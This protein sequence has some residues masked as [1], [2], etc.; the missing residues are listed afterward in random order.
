MIEKNFRAYKDVTTRI[1]I[2]N[3]ELAKLKSDWYSISGI[4][5]DDVKIKG[6]KPV[7]IADQLHNIVEKEKELIKLINQKEEIRRVHEKEISKLTDDKKRMILTF[8][9]LDQYSIKEIAC[10]LKSSESHIKKLK[11]KAIDEFIE[12][13]MK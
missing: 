9:F 11:R 4:K 3:M 10:Y 8:Y 12:L 7:D 13:N 2:K 6:T 5:Y 1:R